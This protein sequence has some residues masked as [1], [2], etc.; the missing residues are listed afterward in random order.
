[1]L[2]HQCIHAC[3][4]NELYDNELHDN[5]LYENELFDNELY[6]IYHSVDENAYG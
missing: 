3:A 2:S 5:E 1:M 4:D 6:D